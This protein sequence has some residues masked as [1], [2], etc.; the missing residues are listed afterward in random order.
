M[1]SLAHFG[2]RLTSLEVRSPEADRLSKLYDL[3]GWKDLT[4]TEGP[5]RWRFGL[6]IGSKDILL[7]SDIEHSSE[8]AKA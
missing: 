2:I 1:Q 3:L 7:S 8:K 4:I 6:R 5:T